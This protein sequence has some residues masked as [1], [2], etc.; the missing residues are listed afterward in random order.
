[1][2]V[3]FQHPLEFEESTSTIMTCSENV[4]SGWEL[5]IPNKVIGKVGQILEMF[6]I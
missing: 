1:M 4:I 5:R 3:G 2:V 6:S